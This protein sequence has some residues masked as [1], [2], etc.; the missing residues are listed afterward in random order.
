[1]LTRSRNPHIGTIVDL[2]PRPPPTR[3]QHHQPVNQV[4]EPAPP[5]AKR[6]LIPPP[7]TASQVDKMLYFERVFKDPPNARALMNR[8]VPF[9]Q[10]LPD[11]DG[12]GGG[13]S[14]FRLLQ[15]NIN[16][17]NTEHIFRAAFYLREALWIRAHLEDENFVFVRSQ[18]GVEFRDMAVELGAI[19]PTLRGMS[20]KALHSLHDRLVKER[21]ALDAFK[22]TLTGD[23]WRGT[24]LATIAADIAY[25]DKMI[26][27]RETRQRGLVNE[28]AA[29]EEAEALPRDHAIRQSPMEVR[30]RPRKRDAHHAL[31]DAGRTQDAQRPDEEVDDRGSDNGDVYVAA[32]RSPAPPAGVTSNQR[33][34]ST[35]ITQ[36]QS[37]ETAARTALPLEQMAAP[38]DTSDSSMTSGPSVPRHLTSRTKRR[39]VAMAP[40]QSEQMAELEHRLTA[41]ESRLTNFMEDQAAAMWRFEQGL[42]IVNRRL[43]DNQMSLVK[44][45]QYLREEIDR[46]LS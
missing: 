14:R 4:P 39:A 45:L 25:V 22:L 3:E 7:E 31:L 41:M 42:M 24:R 26:R 15:F 33:S 6:Q 36:P 19:E 29:G 11:I 30:N 5:R 34:L 12:Q 37:H 46:R 13:V 17:S 10:A 43:D 23:K 40:A 35:S 44:G 2:G 18:Y 28:E 9:G 20:S 21:I 8:V 32:S 38:G 27:E 1:M 16:G